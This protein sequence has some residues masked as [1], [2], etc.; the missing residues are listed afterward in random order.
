MNFIVKIFKKIIKRIASKAY[1]LVISKLAGKRVR[2]IRYYCCKLLFKELGKGVYISDHVKILSPDKIKIK[3]NVRIVNSVILDGR[4]G[5]SIGEDTL[6]GFQSIILTSTHK[7]DRVDIPIRKQGMF[8]KP[9]QIGKDVW[10]GARVIIQ[11]GVTIGDKA[12]VGSGAVVTKDVPQCAVVGGVP[13]KIIKYRIE[14][15]N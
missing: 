8:K 4:G 5:L 6:V 13:A 11:P 15:E 1:V 3:D 2:R 14:N 7:S 12:I 9:V 10:I